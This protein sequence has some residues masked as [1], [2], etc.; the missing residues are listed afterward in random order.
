MD[1]AHADPAT[2]FFRPSRPE[3]LWLRRLLRG[4]DPGGIGGVDSVGGSSGN[5]IASSVP[6]V[7]VTP[8]GAAASSSGRQQLGGCSG[9]GSSSGGGLFVDA[10]RVFFPQR[11]GAFTVWSTATQARENNYGSR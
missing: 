4:D 5:G 2:D 8:A 6:S 1:R 9:G 3:R 7:E 11:R 10:F